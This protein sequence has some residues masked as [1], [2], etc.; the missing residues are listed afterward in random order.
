VC[1]VDR[2]VRRDLVSKLVQDAHGI[3]HRVGN[4]PDVEEHV[5]V[6]GDA[7]WL[8]ADNG[9]VQVNHYAADHHVLRWQV[10]GEL[11]QPWPQNVIGSVGQWRQ[12]G[13]AEDRQVWPSTI[14]Q[15]RTP[16]RASNSVAASTAR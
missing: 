9:S 6:A 3:S 14:A 12:N 7:G 1:G 4:D 11:E 15:L 10:L 13:L 2:A 5:D 8:A 16:A